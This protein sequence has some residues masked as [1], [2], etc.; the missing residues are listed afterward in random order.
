VG[1]GGPDHDHVDLGIAVGRVE[2]LVQLGE[3]LSVLGVANLRP[4]H[5]HEL[6]RAAALDEDRLVSHRIES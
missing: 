5:R 3:E 1:A 4:V 2:S 6:D